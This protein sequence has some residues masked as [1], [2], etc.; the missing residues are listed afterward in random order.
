[1]KQ[2]G[3]WKFVDLVEKRGKESMDDFNKYYEQYLHRLFKEGKGDGVVMIFDFDGFTL[4]NFNNKQSFQLALRQVSTLEKT[5]RVL[6]E[7]F[8][9]NSKC[10]TTRARDCG[11]I[12][13]I[14]IFIFVTANF[15]AQTFLNIARP[16]IGTVLQNAEIYGTQKDKWLPKLLKKVPKEVLPEEYFEK[17]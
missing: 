14:R 6:K 2:F 5:S 7:L 17:P 15:A 12:L 4:N 1:M 8:V 11:S 13:F 16:V 3:K 10:Q 9:V